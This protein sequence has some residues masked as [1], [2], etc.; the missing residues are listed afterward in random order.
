M[1]EFFKDLKVVELA[2]VLAGPS[3]GMFFAEL[4]AEVIK[5]E[6][7]PAGGDATREWR[8]PGETKDGP[9][10]Y[11]C[12][13]N[14]GKTHLFL[15]LRDSADRDRL[16]SE[17]ADADIVLTNYRAETAAKL[18]V[19]YADLAALNENLIFIGLDGFE[20]SDKAAYDVVL[21][22]ET[23]WISMTGTDP[24]LPAKLPVALI[25]I[26]AGHQIK[27]AALLALLKRAKTG[28]GSEVK[29]SLEK[30]SLAA[31][32]NQATNYLMCGHVAGPAGTLHPNI[33]PYGDAFLTADG[34]RLVLAVGS[35]AQFEK[36]CTV[37][38][39]SE[40]STDPRFATNT[41]RVTHRSGLQEILAKA[42]EKMQAQEAESKLSAEGIPY[43][44]VRALDEVLESPTAAAMRLRDVQEGREAARL[45]GLAFTTDFL[46]T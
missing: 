18:G 16:Y 31:L 9:S 27:E 22:A 10:A 34:R 37:L 19:G 46:R 17:I 6:N 39:I 43:G 25:D 3:A 12:S 45:S 36:L 30:S 28:R 7:K 8:L 13:V 15:D 35:N 41:A 1:S 14:W 26:L 24:A 40:I 5:V 23:G 2:A 20:H 4:G 32:A 44:M 11:F 38:E 29:C 33:A 42:F 21:Q